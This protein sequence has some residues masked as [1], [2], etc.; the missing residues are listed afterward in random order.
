MPGE[1]AA[2]GART[3]VYLATSPE[4]VRVTGK[5]FD[6]CTE[7]AAA[8]QALDQQLA[9]QLWAWSE[10]AVRDFKQVQEQ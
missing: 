7:V 8:A 10:E 2:N 4:V 5:Y 3:S 1:A 6:N 9:R